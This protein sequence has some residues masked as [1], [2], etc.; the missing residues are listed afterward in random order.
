[1]PAD[2][3]WEINPMRNDPI[4]EE[5][6]QIRDVLAAQQNYDVKAI[7]ADLRARQGALG[8]R[9]VPQ[10]NRLRSACERPSPVRDFAKE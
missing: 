5:V 6:R 4:V 7:F 1:M 2:N 10:R 9:L 8:S 3:R